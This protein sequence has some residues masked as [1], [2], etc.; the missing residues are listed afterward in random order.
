MIKGVITADIIDYTKL[1]D[2]DAD[3][4]LEALYRLDKE[5]I[6]VRTNTESSIVV[7]R[8]DNIQL[9]VQ[10]PDQVLKLALQLKTALNRIILHPMQKNNIKIDVRIAIGLGNISAYRKKVNESTGNAYTNSGRTLD[11]M[12]SKKRLLSINSN[13]NHLDDELNTEFKLLEVIMNNW[14]ISSV[15]VINLLL[16]GLNE[17]EI[18]DELKISQS[19]VNQ[20]KKTAGWS[21]IEP[22]LYRY[23]ELIKKT[24]QNE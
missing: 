9:E 10:D 15:E 2:N 18:A 3:Q 5:W 21:G 7:K 22:L 13:I 6:S 4:V 12:K 20:R 8:G 11:M 17:Q 19:A 24:L 1:T 23:E 14:K 16:K